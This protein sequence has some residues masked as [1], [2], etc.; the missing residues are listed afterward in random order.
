[1]KN[2]TIKKLLGS[3]IALGTLVVLSGTAAQAQ[4]IQ[5]DPVTG[6]SGQLSSGVTTPPYSLGD[7]SGLLAS[8]YSP[9]AGI[10]YIATAAGQPA[11]TT[12]R[13]ETFTSDGT[14][15]DFPVGQNLLDT[16]DYA[17]NNPTGP[18]EID[19]STAV[20]AFGLQAQSA[21][22]DNYSLTFSVYNSANTLLG[23]F[24]TPTVDNTVGA[25]QSLFV[26]AESTSGAV[27]SKVVL[28]SFSTAVGLDPNGGSNDLYFGPLTV[29][30]AV[31]EASTA[32]GFSFGILMFGGVIWSARKRQVDT[33]SQSTS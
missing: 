25:G 13:F 28:S 30:A 19:F 12:Q 33:A 22:I 1:M 29:G 3:T 17:S 9:S 5:F 27:I 7:S 21:R 14:S 6:N 8:P 16:F 2:Y 23:S 15:L 26:G 32:I 10:T 11:G 18:L 20:G 4:L 24:T 31:P